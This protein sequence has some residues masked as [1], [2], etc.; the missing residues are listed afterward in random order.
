MSLPQ[1][2]AVGLYSGVK[3]EEKY[4]SLSDHDAGRCKKQTK[5]ELSDVGFYKN[6]RRM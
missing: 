3:W 5:G 6:V 4:C 2:Q 1:R